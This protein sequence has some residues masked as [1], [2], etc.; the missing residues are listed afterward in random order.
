MGVKPKPAKVKTALDEAR[1]KLEKAEVNL[2]LAKTRV[3]D[4]QAEHMRWLHLSP[5]SHATERVKTRSANRIYRRL[6]AAKGA[7]DAAKSYVREAK[8]RLRAAREISRFQRSGRKTYRDGEREE[9]YPLEREG[10]NWNSYRRLA[11]VEEIV[12]EEK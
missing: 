11:A 9:K 1:A 2:G 4:L 5:D 7:L 12:K 6:L 10:K 8:A 3:R